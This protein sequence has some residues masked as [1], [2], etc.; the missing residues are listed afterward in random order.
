MLHLS[1][2]CLG[3]PKAPRNVFFP[4][5]N[6]VLVRSGAY[7][8]K[9]RV[10]FRVPVHVTKYE[11]REYLRQI[12]G[13]RVTRVNTYIKV[14]KVGR[15]A[16]G[17]YFRCG[18]VYK[19]A[20][21]TLEDDVPDTVKMVISA[22]QPGVN[23]AATKYDGVGQQKFNRSSRFRPGATR[24]LDWAPRHAAAWT[25][26]LPTLLRGDLSLASG[27]AQNS[28]ARRAADAVSLADYSGSIIAES[29]KPGAANGIQS[30]FPG[31]SPFS[32]MHGVFPTARTPGAR[33]RGQQPHPQLRTPPHANEPSW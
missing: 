22:N 33:Q 27:T 26:P 6:F 24:R 10:A 29:T 31:A 28:A 19:K 7:L 32:L 14:P 11:I 23:P 2:A 25:E 1:R 3:P 16:S 5:F 9:N 21:L 4:W 18:P 20:I 13:A 15:S 30:P 8:E 17:R 12:Y